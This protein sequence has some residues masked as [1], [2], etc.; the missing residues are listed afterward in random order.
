[1]K[2]RF[3]GWLRELFQRSEKNEVQTPPP[4]WAV[5]AATPPVQQPQARSEPAPVSPTPERPGNSD[6]ELSMPLRPVVERLV[7]E[8]RAKLTMPVADLEQASI[9]ISAKQVLPQ[10]AGGS[11]KILFGQLRAAAPDLFR[12]GTEHDTFPVSLP[13]GEVLARLNPK[14]LARAPAQKVVQVSDDISGP[15][16][17]EAK[18]AGRA[19]VP[20]LRMPSPPAPAPMTTEQNRPSPAAPRPD[21]AEA[22]R[23]PRKTPPVAVKP[24]PSAPARPTTAPATDSILA[25]I[26]AVAERWPQPLREE[27]A[28]LNLAETGIALPLDA[29]EAGLKRG[30]VVFPWRTLR[31]WLRP[32]PLLAVSLRD[33]SELELP[34]KILVPL[35][36]AQ[37]PPPARQ[38]ARLPAAE[39]PNLISALPQPLAVEPAPEPVGLAAPPEPVAPP[40]APVSVVPAAPPEPAPIVRDTTPS[41]A[42][43]TT[44]LA[45]VA[46]PVKATEPA[47]PPEF[48]SPET[49][50]APKPAASEPVVKPEAIPAGKT[51]KTEVSVSTA[52]TATH[53]A[54]IEGKRPPTPPAAED[55]I[56]RR[57]TPKI[58]VGRAVELAGVAGAIVALP[59]GLSVARRVPQGTNAELLAAF[60]PQ[61]FDRASQNAAELQMG[62]LT[63]LSFTVGDVPWAIFRANIFRDSPVY[64]AAFGRPGQPF[65]GAELAA[66][67]AELDYRKHQ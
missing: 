52:A 14:W 23:T 3:T 59:G 28:Q 62:S 65:P 57:A 31:A 19:A 38:R 25:P 39:I 29:L 61:M 66:L 7:P 24:A 12:A 50:A 16:A 4:P 18:P 36:L 40:P 21:A 42:P 32:K 41:P 33:N 27:L 35:F 46:E 15:F 17:T 64:F 34:L 48:A 1:V 5:P 30:R 13:L 60:F 43:P 63:S 54:P 11:V 20:V 56:T 53:A 49:G 55:L 8:L 2:T 44:P 37:C 6:E 22:G 10:L 26:S 47:K 9:S 58:I 45:E 51:D 67:A